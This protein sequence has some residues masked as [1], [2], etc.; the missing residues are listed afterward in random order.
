MSSEGT[1]TSH[2]AELK[3]LPPFC[4]FDEPQLSRVFSAMQ[5][6]S[7][8]AR[9]VIQHAG[10]AADGIYILLSGRAQIVHADGQGREYVTQIIRA[11]DFFGE[12]GFFEA[13]SSI[14]SIRTTEASEA[15][16]IPR[17][18]VMQCLRTNAKA[19][20]CMLE[21][22]AKRFG[23]CHRK[24]AELALTDVYERVAAVLLE[25]TSEAAPEPVLPFGA[26]ELARQVGASRE[27]TSRVV[28]A[29]IDR[30]L[31]SRDK[32]KL[33]VVDRQALG[34]D[35]AQHGEASRQVPQNRQCAARMA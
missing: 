16:Y 14:G 32:R 18:V 2:S 6:R 17:P 30:G 13:G 33:I 34:R 3:N 28:R 27:M 26:E 24:L 10:S 4:W 19:A 20:M 29:M 23:A 35:L 9:A 31:V 8:P 12:L 1:I 5:R 21:K 22:V 25:N 15:L 11:H 7:Y